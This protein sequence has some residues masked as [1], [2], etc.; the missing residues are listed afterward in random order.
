M[1]RFAAARAELVHVAADVA[2]VGRDVRLTDRLAGGDL[3]GAVA[4][5]QHGE[6][7]RELVV[8]PRRRD[9]QDLALGELG[10]NSSFVDAE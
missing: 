6:D 10:A 2:A 4:A 1:A 8:R 7:G 5:Q 9:V 3:D